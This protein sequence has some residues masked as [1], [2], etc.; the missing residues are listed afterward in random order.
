M[1]RRVS[2]ALSHGAVHRNDG[3]FT[4]QL[5]GPQPTRDNPALVPLASTHGLRF[6]LLSLVWARSCKWRYQREVRQV[7]TQVL[8]WD[9]AA[10]SSKCAVPTCHF[11]VTP[12]CS[13]TGGLTLQKKTRRVLC[14]CSYSS[15]SSVRCSIWEV[16][17]PVVFSGEDFLLC[18]HF[19]V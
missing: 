7:S 16:V 10:I 19:G 15:S 18:E 2:W 3:P 17:S 4:G 13:V 6:L 14:L 1:Q 12:H 5:R 8:M 11:W 9:G